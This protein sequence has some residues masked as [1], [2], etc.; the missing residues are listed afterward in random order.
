MLSRMLSEGFLSC[1][2]SCRVAFR[3]L[4]APQKLCWRLSRPNE[5]SSLC[6]LCSAWL[7][8]ISMQIVS[9]QRSA[10]FF[11]KRGRML[12]ACCIGAMAR[13]IQPQTLRLCLAYC[14][15]AGPLA[16]KQQHSVRSAAWKAPGL[17]CQARISLGL[18][19]LRPMLRTSSLWKSTDYPAGNSCEDAQLYDNS[20][21][22]T[23]S[24]SALRWFA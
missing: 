10:P 11:L 12:E 4:L 22:T 14:L 9:C 15:R 1:C 8:H 6:L 21:Q 20:D 17:R 7:L 13:H 5:M 23:R 2:S 16:F 19:G 3:Q 18:R 24:C